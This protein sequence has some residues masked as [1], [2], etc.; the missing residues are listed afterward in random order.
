MKEHLTNLRRN[1]N[2][3]WCNKCGSYAVDTIFDSETTNIQEH[4]KCLKCGNSWIEI[5]SLL[6]QWLKKRQGVF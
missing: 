3:S 4:K 1:E 5:D 2:I 6:T